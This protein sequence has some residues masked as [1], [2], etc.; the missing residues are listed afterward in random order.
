[1]RT[2][3]GWAAIVL[4]LVQVAPAMAQVIGSRP[5]SS[6]LTGVSPA[7]AS[8]SMHTS[9]LL[10]GNTRFSGFNPFSI[11]RKTGQNLRFPGATGGSSIP[12]SILPVTNPFP[13][14]LVPF[15]E[16]P[17]FPTSA[18]LPSMKVQTSQR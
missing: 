3:A 17:P 8:K 10:N 13:T 14:K 6:F 7:D 4:A 16:N 18:I 9:S 2:L 11:F 5:A 1:M 12:G 15:P